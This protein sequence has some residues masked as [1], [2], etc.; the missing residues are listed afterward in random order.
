M[1]L[2][3]SLSKQPAV[4]A[5]LTGLQDEEIP[6]P[7]PAKKK[8]WWWQLLLCMLLLMTGYYFLVLNSGLLQLE[9]ETD[10]RTV[11]KVYWP[12][13]SGNFSEHHMTELLIEPGKTS[14]SIRV[15]NTA[16]VDYLRLDPGEKT[17]WINIKSL[18]IKQWGY[19]DYHVQSRK[20]FQNLEILSGVE[21][22][23]RH[24][25][26]VKLQIMSKDPQLKLLLPRRER[27][28]SPLTDT[29]ELIRFFCV[30][31]LAI[32]GFF[33]FRHFFND[34]YFLP[35][36][37]AMALG[38]IVA[39]ALISDFNTHPD[40]YVHVTAGK[41]YTNH[42]LPPKVGDPSITHTYSHYGVSRL[43]SGEVIYFLAGKYLQL[44]QP[45]YL[46]PF[47]LLRFFNV[48]LFGALIFFAFQK[49]DFRFF[50]LPFLISPQIWY[51]FSYFNSDAFATFMSLV[52]AYQLAGKQSA[53]NSLIVSE[54]TKYAWLKI[55]L[56]GLL[57]GFLLLL[58][59][60]FY[61]LYIFLFCYFIWKVWALRPEWS[62]KKI[63]R[64]AAILLVGCSVFAGIRLTDA[65]VNDFNKGEL[66]FEARRQYA[67]ELFNPDTPL[68]KRHFYLEMRKR[69]TTLKHFLAADRWGEKSFRTS[70]GVYG[71]TQYSGSFVYYNYVRYV[72]LAL[73]LTVIG[74][75]AYRGQAAGISL[76]TIALGSSLLLII[77]A[78]WHAWTVDFQAQ[79]RY[80]LPI[81]PMAAVL[82]YHCR[83]II[84][85]PLF[86]TLFFILF[87]LSIYNFVLVGLRDI[88]KYVM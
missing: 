51:I 17:A 36:L 32:A 18:H 65:W 75:I 69:G 78:C 15:S 30:I 47:F 68:E 77:V 85:R 63:F 71:Y 1:N 33:L 20:D 70:F 43:H 3:R 8:H 56:L 82:F 39:M 27:L 88:G 84:F 49:R 24:D 25:Q 76:L 45:F 22:L 80:F 62:R 44:L 13:K 58:K 50:L 55:I 38:L 67:D 37:G 11:F 31:F 12:N 14:Y 60:N 40:E 73:L 72:S 46:K 34:S 21:A 29:T 74:S 5:L 64:I 28:F 41:Y 79:G 10:T 26:G 7:S 42:N 16:H 9:L 48:L 4:P 23:T 57:L 54:Q 83:R 19:P 2:F 52:A 87:S 81:I 35:V 61:F 66:L 53:L 86:Y 6:T 59:Q